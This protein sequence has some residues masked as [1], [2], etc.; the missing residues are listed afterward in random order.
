MALVNKQFSLNILTINLTGLDKLV[1]QLFKW[2]NIQIY[3]TL[4]CEKITFL[5]QKT[6]LK[7][8]NFFYRQ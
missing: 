4:L 2:Q 7:T 8:F 6:L 1:Y 5:H 3:N